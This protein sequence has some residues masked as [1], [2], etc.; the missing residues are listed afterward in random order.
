MNYSLMVKQPNDF[1]CV[2]KK[3]FNVRQRLGDI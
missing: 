1:K 2:F 3:T